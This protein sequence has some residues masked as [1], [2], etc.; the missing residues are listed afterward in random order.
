[1]GERAHKNETTTMRKINRAISREHICL[2]M[3]QGRELEKIGP[4]KFEM[5]DGLGEGARLGG[6]QANDRH[7]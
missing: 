2:M 3:E 4:T 1:M 7:P 5:R 6:L